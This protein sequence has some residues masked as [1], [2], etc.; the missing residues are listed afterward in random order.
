MEDVLPL[1]ISLLIAVVLL[2]S[3]WILFSKAGKPGWYS[4]IPILNVVALIDIAGKPWFWIIGF[5]IPVVNFIVTVLIWHGI[6][7]GFGQGVLF[8]LGLLF[9]S[10]VFIPI[11]AFGGYQYTRPA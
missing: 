10:P 3:L 7:R 9:L 6:S 8:T 5:F 11:L 2:A 1:I 4:L